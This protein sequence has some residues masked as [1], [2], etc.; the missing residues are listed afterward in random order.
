MTEMEVRYRISGHRVHHF[1]IQVMHYY[2]DEAIRLKLTLPNGSTHAVQ[3]VQVADKKLQDI[4]EQW[5]VKIKDA[6]V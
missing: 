2:S 4:A 6:L 3:N 5:I 1:M